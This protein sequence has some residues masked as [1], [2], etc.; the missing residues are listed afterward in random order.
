MLYRSKNEDLEV[1]VRDF[2]RACIGNNES[3]KSKWAMLLLI[4][5]EDS[6]LKWCK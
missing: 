3:K 5:L 1:F 4:F 6:V 2:K